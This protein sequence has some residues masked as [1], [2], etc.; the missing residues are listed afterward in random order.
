MRT[1][2]VCNASVIVVTTKIMMLAITELVNRCFRKKATGLKFLAWVDIIDDPQ[3]YV[4]TIA[5]FFP[6]IH[7]S[8]RGS[9]CEVVK[10]AGVTKLVHKMTAIRR[11]VNTC[12]VVNVRSAVSASYV[13][14]T[15]DIRSRPP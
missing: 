8:M 9:R 12:F 1:V 6:V 13:S 3:G 7:C 15:S 2:D 11:N 5:I 4:R 14:A 10:Y